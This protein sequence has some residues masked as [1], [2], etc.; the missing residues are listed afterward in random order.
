[1]KYL[2]FD[3]DGTLLSHE[4]GIIDSTVN[5]LKMAKENGH[6]IFICTGRSYAEIPEKIYKFEFDGIVAAAGGYVKIGNEVIYNK[7]LPEHLVDNLIYFMEKFNLP[8]VLEGVQKVYSHKDAVYRSE[9][10]EKELEKKLKGKYFEHSPLD[11][12]IRRK[13]SIDDY[14]KDRT[15][16]SKATV[17][18]KEEAQ[19]D[20]LRKYIDR[21]FDFIYYGNIVELVAKGVSKFTG[22]EIALD[23]FDAKVEESFAIGDSAN[24]FEMIRDAHIGVAMGNASD[25]VKKIADYVTSNV[26]DDGIYN[27]LKHFNII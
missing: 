14:L 15:D 10:K 16:I 13:L 19:I 8:F 1:M 22:I 21:D 26:E 20:E 23:Y 17:Y 11:Y 2:F 6:K 27:A 3:I 5:A 7:L 12:I 18:A 25:D 4:I 24:D 9:K